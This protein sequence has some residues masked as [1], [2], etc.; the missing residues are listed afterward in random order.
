MRSHRPR[1]PFSPTHGSER[2]PTA[3]THVPAGPDSGVNVR[4]HTRPA[5]E[6]PSQQL[7]WETLVSHHAAAAQLRQAHDRLMKR[8]AMMETPARIYPVVVGLPNA[9]APALTQEVELREEVA[10]PT[11]SVGLLNPNAIP[12]YWSVTG[13][14]QPSARA[15][16]TPPNALLVLP[17]SAQ[18]V[19]VG[20]SPT[21]LN[22]IG[23]GIAVVCFLIR[24][25]T[26]QPAFLGKGA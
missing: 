25:F 12:I 5:A 9:A 22:T 23:V 15:F 13:T 8:L 10:E 17:I 3:P 24:Y 4:Q 16:S 21:D 2:T 19:G 7:M 20:A 14:A 11:L 1:D 6:A 26:V 18:W